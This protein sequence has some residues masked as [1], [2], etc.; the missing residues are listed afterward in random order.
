LGSFIAPKVGIKNARVVVIQSDIDVAPAW[1]G[2][3]GVSHMILNP[4]FVGAAS[5]IGKPCA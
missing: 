5:P 1:F 3:F 4:Y 2:L